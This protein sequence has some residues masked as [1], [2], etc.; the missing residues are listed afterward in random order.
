ME[1]KQICFLEA[2]PLLLPCSGKHL[3]SEIDSRYMQSDSD[4]ILNSCRSP[5]RLPEHVLLLS[6]PSAFCARHQIANAPWVLPEN[7]RGEQFDC[8]ACACGHLDWFCRS[9][10]HLSLQSISKMSFGPMSL[11]VSRIKSLIRL[12]WPS[13]CDP[14]KG[15]DQT[16]ISVRRR[17]PASALS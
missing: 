10:Q 11:L 15:F 6:R 12:G 14:Q 4:N 2:V 17:N 9:R 16:G 5:R 3:R 13:V 7:H 8:S 1:E